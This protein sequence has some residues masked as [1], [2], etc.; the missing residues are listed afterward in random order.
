MAF[1]KSGDGTRIH[2]ELFGRRQGEPLL[3]VHGLGADIR[4]WALQRRALGRRFRCVAVDNRGV[5]L[6]ERPPGPYDLEVMAEDALDALDAAGFDSAHVVGA[7]MGGIIAQIIAVRFPERVRSL[8]LACTAC[9]HLPW[10]RDLLEE[11]AEI[12]QAQGMRA[13]VKR[14]LRW[15][16]GP[17]SLRRLLPALNVLGPLAM[18]VPVASFVAQIHAIL[19]QTD[20]VRFLLEQVRV[21]ALVTVGSQDMLT[22]QGDS[23]ELASLLPRSEL[24]V[25]RGGAHLFMV[26]NAL[27]FNRTVTGFLDEVATSAG[28]R[29]ATAIRSRARGRSGSVPASG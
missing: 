22:P 27:T 21:P 24:A 28:R 20:E 7:S 10:R 8:V 16:V 13:M 14:N 25:I 6:S 11:W 18:N 5:G 23:E 1:T 4:G 3:L 12:A 15:L 19:D 2:Y 9:R 29:P 17:R 26:E